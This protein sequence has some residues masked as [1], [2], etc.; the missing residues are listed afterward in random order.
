MGEM[1]NT[2]TEKAAKKSWLKGLKSEYKKIVWSDK[3]TLAKQTAAVLAVTVILG[4]AIYVMDYVMGLGIA[5]I[6]G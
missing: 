4:A 2:T 3:E 6:I 1:A 5:A